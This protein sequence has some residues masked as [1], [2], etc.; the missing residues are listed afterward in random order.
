MKKIAIFVLCILL[1]VSVFAQSDNWYFSFSMGGTYPVGS[2]GKADINNQKSGFAKNGFALLLD[3]TY[4]VSDHWGLKGMVLINTSPVDRMALGSKLE[5]RMSSSI[6]V[7]DADRTFLA[8]SV[9]SWMSNAILAG[10]VYSIAFDRTFWDFYLL[11]GMNVAYLPQQKLIFE[12]PANNWF[13]LD[14]N[15]STTSVS[16]G[17]L[18]GTALRF[19]VSD[20]LKLRIGLDYYRS[21]ASV[22]YEQIKV[23]KQGETI[24][25]ENLGKGSA[26]IPVEIFTGSIG[27][28]YYLN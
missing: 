25:T 2:F 4:P 10:P 26:S 22:P 19:P 20:R 12:K 5:G 16:Y 28:V 18:C 7:P 8:L 1:S 24:L 3:A 23:T 14:R 27:F 21:Q 13:Y 6:T 17:I 15:T 9:D 11:T